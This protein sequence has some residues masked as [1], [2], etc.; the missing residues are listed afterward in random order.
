MGQARLERVDAQEG[1]VPPAGGDHA[2]TTS[3]P[4][5]PQVDEPAPGPSVPDQD[6]DGGLPAVTVVVPTHNRPEMMTRAVR[7]VVDQDYDGEIEVV[8]VFDACEPFVPDVPTSTTRTLR[9]RTNR[10]AR[11]LAGARNSG[12][13]AA[14]HDL[15]AFLDDDDAWQPGKLRAQVEV[16]RRHPEAVLVGTAIEVQAVDR[17]HLRLVPHDPVTHAHLLHDRLPG[18]HS[19]SFLFR[20][21]VLTDI[22]MVDEQLP[23]SY[24]EDYDLLLRTARAGAIRVVNEPLTVVTWQGQSFFFG[25]WAQYADALEWMLDRHPEFRS[26]PRAV[27]RIESQIAF[28]RSAAGQRAL[29]RRWAVRALRHHPRQPKAALA[30][31]I[32]AGLL[33]TGWVVRVV[34]RMG[35]G[36]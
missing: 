27:G 22:G 31:G 19:S 2:P 15:V 14:S 13:A 10:R 34:Q 8:I 16:L 7:S 23:G 17:T 12:I 9:T 4:S 18:L 1:G 26:S 3:Q 24:G 6:R 32:G 20:K 5:F 11:G 21:E 29:G 30:W 28:A 36:I 33:R 25:K 35:K